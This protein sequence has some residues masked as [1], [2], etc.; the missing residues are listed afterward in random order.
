M[1]P[2]F[3]SVSRSAMRFISHPASE[4]RV[5][6]IIEQNQ[7]GKNGV[8]AQDIYNTKN[9]IS[10]GYDTHRQVS[11]IYR[12]KIG[13]LSNKNI[14]GLTDLFKNADST[15]SVQNYMISLSVD[16]QYEIGIQVLRLLG[17]KI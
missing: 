12:T 17:E 8:V 6:G 16:K 9:T 2:A 5:N 15:L 11:G 3:S 4:V 10:L 14:S 7:I 1:E 13:N